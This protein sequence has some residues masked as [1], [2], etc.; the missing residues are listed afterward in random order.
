MRSARF[1]RPSP[2]D[3]VHG[4]AVER[5]LVEHLGSDYALVEL[6]RF[7]GRFTLAVDAEWL[8][9]ARSIGEEHP[10]LMEDLELPASVLLAVVPGW[11]DDWRLGADS[12]T[13][14]HRRNGVLHLCVGSHSNN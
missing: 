6:E 13:I 14:S 7:E 4:C 3:H 1:H 12:V 10:G 2:V 11:Q 8:R 5:Q 9:F